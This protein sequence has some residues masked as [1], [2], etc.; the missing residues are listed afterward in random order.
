M[1]ITYDIEVWIPSIGSYKEVSSASYAG[2][3]QARRANI[4]YR[5]EGEKK[6]R[7]VHTLNAS[8]LA[9]SRLLPAIVEQCQQPDG[10]IRVPE[11]LRDWLKTDTIT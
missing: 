2:D 7:Y 8:A 10:S 4:R 5:P 6:T 9:T 11:P 3:Y 1:Q